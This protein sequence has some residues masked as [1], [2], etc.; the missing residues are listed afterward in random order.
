MVHVIV[1]HGMSWCF[2]ASL[3]PIQEQALSKVLIVHREPAGI[4]TQDPR[5]KRANQ[6]LL[7]KMLR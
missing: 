3:A 4:R 1:G 6:Q 7:L 2:G 5:P